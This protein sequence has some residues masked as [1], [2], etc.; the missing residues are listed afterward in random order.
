MGIDITA[1]FYGLDKIPVFHEDS[2][3]K[4]ICLLSCKYVGQ[5]VEFSQM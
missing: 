2:L 3:L 5:T 1:I 4:Q